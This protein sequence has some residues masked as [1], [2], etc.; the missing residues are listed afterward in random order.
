MFFV[1]HLLSVMLFKYRLFSTTSP[2]LPN[3][4]ANNLFYL[5]NIYISRLAPPTLLITYLT[6]L[7]LDAHNDLY[8]VLY[9]ILFP[10]STRSGLYHHHHAAA[11]GYSF[12]SI[13]CDVYCNGAA[14]WVRCTTPIPTRDPSKKHTYLVY[15]RKSIENIYRTAVLT[16]VSRGKRPVENS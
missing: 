6:S 9:S 14:T 1:R 16:A 4:L 5:W 8:H 11:A 12:I 2:S 10:T 3:D 15:A 13:C 7:L